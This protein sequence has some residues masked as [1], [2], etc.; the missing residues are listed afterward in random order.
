MY[1]SIFD[2][3]SASRVKRTPSVAAAAVAAATTVLT[4]EAVKSRRKMYT[5]ESPRRPDMGSVPDVSAVSKVSDENCSCSA[6]LFVSMRCAW[7]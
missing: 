4:A 2:D 3:A 5:L 6:A 7:Q 1:R